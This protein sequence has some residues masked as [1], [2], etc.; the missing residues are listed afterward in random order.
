MGHLQY[1]LTM[2]EYS[3]SILSLNINQ[4]DSVVCSY[5]HIV[6]IQILLAKFII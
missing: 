2:N 1:D 6:G 5:V 4:D 3:Q